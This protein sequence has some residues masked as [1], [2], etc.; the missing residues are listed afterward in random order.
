MQVTEELLDH[1][2]D[3]TAGDCHLCH[4]R[5]ARRNY[6]LVG[7][8]GGWEIDHS[9][10]RVNGGTNHRNNLFPAHISCNRS[11]QAGSSRSIRA[12]NGYT[13]APL[14]LEARER[15]RV[16][17]ALLAAGTGGLGAYYLAKRYDGTRDLAVPLACIGAL[18]AGA[19]AYWLMRS[20]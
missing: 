14:S 15:A 2:Y 8:R 6:G 18:S 11:K 5:L 20:P 13:R 3:R 4:T 10:A 9:V 12:R 16:Q 7:R 19:L 17:L 1:V